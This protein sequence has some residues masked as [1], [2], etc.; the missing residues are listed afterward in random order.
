M[1][2]STYH[3]RDYTFGQTM[4]TMRTRVGLTQAELAKILGVTRKTIGAWELGSSYPQAEH[5]KQF[6]AL[7]IQY[8][9]FSAGQVVEDVRTLWESA[10]QKVLFDKAWLTTLLPPSEAPLSMQPVKETTASAALANWLDWNDAPAVPSFY[11]REWEMELL[12]DWVVVERCRVISVL[13]LGGVGKSALTVS[14]MHLLAEHFEVVIWRSLRNLQTS[15]EFIEGL[16]QVLVPV[17]IIGEATNL[18]RRPGFL[19]EQMRKSRVL[20]VLDN[21]EALLEEGEVSGRMRP[22]FE[23]LEHL[24]NLTAETEHQS[25]VLLTSR[26]VPAVLVPFAGSQETVRSLRLAPLDAASCDKLLSEKELI[27]SGPDRMRLIEAYNG[28]PLALKIVAHTI[29]DLFDGE[30]VPFLD[31]GEVIIGGVRNLLEE[32]FYRLSSLEQSLL[33]WLAILGEPANI[34]KLLEVWAAPVSRALVLEA[35][36]ALYRRSLIERGSKPQEFALQPLVMEYLT[37]WRITQAT[38]EDRQGKLE[39]LRDQLSK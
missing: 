11:G 14:L 37:T 23:S 19:L 4:L 28:N 13:G 9:A 15:E 2:G 26:E 29:V 21:L 33:L 34:D 6:I 25:C 12:T 22:G 38:A 8:R 1:R 36:H 35:L 5:L 10:H 3:E 32:Q 27:G 39:R 7:A 18:E 24:L 16:L 31:K 30:I 17:S 20:L